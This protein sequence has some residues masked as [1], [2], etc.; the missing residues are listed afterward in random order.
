VNYTNDR[1]IQLGRDVHNLTKEVTTY[2]T[3][4]IQDLEERLLACIQGE[5]EKLT[6]Q[7]DDDLAAITPKLP[8]LTTTIEY[9]ST[10]IEEIDGLL[11]K[12]QQL[13]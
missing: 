8:E 11:G 12:L 1:T 4:T 3:D 6:R 10:L 9:G 2:T 13:Q 5:L 7:F